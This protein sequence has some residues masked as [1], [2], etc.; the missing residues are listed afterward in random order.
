MACREI[1]GMDIAPSEAET[2]WTTFI[3]HAAAKLDRLQK[4]PDAANPFAQGEATVERAITLVNECAQ[5][6]RDR[7]GPEK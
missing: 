2:F 1:L 3:D 5:A 7:F 4:A 6:Q